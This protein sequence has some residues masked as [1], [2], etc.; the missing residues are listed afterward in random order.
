ML[1][2]LG[3]IQSFAQNFQFGFTNISNGSSHFG[4]DLYSMNIYN[5]TLYVGGWNKLTKLTSSGYA[6]IPEISS[7]GAVNK[8]R[9]IGQNMY[10]VG[11][12]F[13]VNGISTNVAKYDGNSWQPITAFPAAGGIND[14][15]DFQGE[16][17]GIGNV[18]D[19]K[20]MV[21][22]LINGSWVPVPG[23]PYGG[24]NYIGFE[25]FNDELFAFGHF[26][27][28]ITL[29][30]DSVQCNNIAKWNGAQWTSVGGTQQPNSSYIR[31]AYRWGQKM[32]TSNYDIWDG[33]QWNTVP[34][35]QDHYDVSKFITYKNNLVGAT[36]SGIN[37]FDPANQEWKTVIPGN[38]VLSVPAVLELIDATPLE[39]HTVYTSYSTTNSSE[40]HKLSELF[41]SV[42]DET[43][44]KKTLVFP[45]PTEDLVYV[46]NAKNPIIS[47]EVYNATGRLLSVYLKSPASL[48]SYPAG[49]YTLKIKYKAGNA[50]TRKIIKK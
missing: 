11:Q 32:I 19:S 26:T 7:S 33:S 46:E 6:V 2:L 9:N 15:I 5:G 38:V 16:I 50:E 8:I 13:L 22:R 43:L 20:G 27:H 3:F 47:I 49:H 17:Y 24:N 40:P 23:H 30:G 35:P 34:E 31:T 4:S 48:A 44:N 25:I 1:T 10:I 29:L 36:Y 28:V 21:A 41:L 39:D 12:N 45:N 18:A 37:I 14:I 42:N